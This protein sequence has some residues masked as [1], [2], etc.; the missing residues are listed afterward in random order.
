MQLRYFAR[1]REMLGCSKEQVEL[2]AHVDT[3]EGLFAW[4]RETQ[5]DRFEAIFSAGPVLAAVNE[6][7]ATSGT[8]ISDQDIVALFPPVT[9]G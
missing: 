9:G 4:L 3:V 8:Q 1:Y 2:P 6:E 7:M 5:A